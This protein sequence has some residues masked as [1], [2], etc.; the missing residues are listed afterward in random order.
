MFPAHFSMNWYPFA[1]DRI[2]D[3]ALTECRK[4]L[5]NGEYYL[6]F[7][8]SLL[9]LK[10]LTETHGPSHLQITPA[11]LLLAQSA[12]GIPTLIPNLHASSFFFSSI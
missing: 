12:T 1:Q 11:L 2:C 9:A 7:P 4:Y 6:A 8:P 10:L 5:H 3:I